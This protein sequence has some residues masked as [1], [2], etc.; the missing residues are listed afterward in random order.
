MVPV[1][2]LTAKVKGVFLPHQTLQTEAARNIIVVGLT[3]DLSHIICLLSVVV[4]TLFFTAAS[5]QDPIVVG[6][7]YNLSD[8]DH[9]SW[10]IWN[11]KL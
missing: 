7:I 1:V 2:K 9:I 11:L 3:L 6:F 8:V 10:E 4:L 5:C